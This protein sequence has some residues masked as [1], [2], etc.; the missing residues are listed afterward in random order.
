MRRMKKE[1]EMPEGIK[2][3]PPMKIA[4]PDSQEKVK[5]E[6]SREDGKGN[7]ARMKDGKE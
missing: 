2:T 4:L 5:D 3:S 1:R 7:V 6:S